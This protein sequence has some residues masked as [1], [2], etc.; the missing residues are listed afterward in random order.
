MDA[1]QRQR[2]GIATAISTNPA[3][4]L[5]DEPTTAPDV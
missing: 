2:V 5:A 3:V 1:G 4:L